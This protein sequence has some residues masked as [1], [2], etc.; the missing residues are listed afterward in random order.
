MLFYHVPV[1]SIFK[2][3]YEN[4][5]QYMV[6]SA[7]ESDFCRQL[8]LWRIC[9]F[10]YFRQ[11]TQMDLLL[12]GVVMQTILI[13]TEIFLTKW[14]HV[15]VAPLF[16]GKLLLPHLS[17]FFSCSH[18]IDTDWN[19]QFFSVNNDINYRQP[20]TRA[21]MNWIKQEHF[22]ASAS[23]H[24]VIFSSTCSYVILLVEMRSCI[25]LFVFFFRVLSLPIIHGMELKIQGESF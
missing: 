4:C 24:G 19:W 23:L 21:I 22:T 14:V 3:I 12:D 8:S 25:I 17:I 11:W 20:E 2:L 16:L 5:S 10:I 1:H 6:N 18:S 15:Y 7:F 9:T 13:S